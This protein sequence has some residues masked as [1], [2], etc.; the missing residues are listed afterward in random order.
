VR[1]QVCA[2][3]FK[4]RPCGPTQLKV[5]GKNGENWGNEDHAACEWEVG[6]NGKPGAGEDLSYYIYATGKRY[7][8]G[9]RR[10]A[11]REKKDKKVPCPMKKKDKQINTN[12]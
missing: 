8:R 1:E 5:D 7:F 11:M 10:A 4:N 3:G 12:A 9:K 2:D 6:P